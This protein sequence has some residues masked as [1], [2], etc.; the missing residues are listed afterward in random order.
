MLQKEIYFYAATFIYRYNS[1]SS[2]GFIYQ[3]SKV[4]KSPTANEVFRE[5]MKREVMI[6]IFFWYRDWTDR[7]IHMWDKSLSW[8]I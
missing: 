8:K 3:Q 2:F 7:T 1:F 5:N 4:D 6:L